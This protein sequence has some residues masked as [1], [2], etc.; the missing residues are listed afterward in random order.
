MSLINQVFGIKTKQP[1][2]ATIQ[3]IF[4]DYTT[5]KKTEAGI[6]VGVNEVV[7]YAPVSQALQMISGDIAK[8][9]LNVYIRQPSL[10][11]NA[12]DVDKKHQAY[13]IVKRRANEQQSA[14]RFWSSFVYQQLLWNNAYAWIKRNPTNGR[15]V[16]LYLLRPDRTQFSIKDGLYYSEIGSGV[17]AEVIALKP[18]DVLHYQGNQV[19][20]VVEPSL[21]KNARTSISVGLAAVNHAA[22]FFGGDCN[23]GGILE[24]PASFEKRAKDNLEQGFQKK[25]AGQA[26]QTVILRDG[27]RFHSIQI[28]AEKSQM[29]ETRTH[30]AR[31]MANW[32]NLPPSKLGIPDAGGYGSRTED[33]R[34]YYDQTLSSRL[35]DISS[36]CDLKLLTRAQQNNDSHYFEHDAT[37]LL[38]M[39][40]KTLAEIYA[41]ESANGATSPDEYRAATN[42]NPRPDGEGGRFYQP[43]ANYV[44]V[45]ESSDNSEQQT[46]TDNQTMAILNAVLS[47]QV[48][49]WEAGSIAVIKKECRR[50]AIGKFSNWLNNFDGLKV[51]EKLEERTKKAGVDFNPSN[52]IENVKREIAN[53]VSDVM[54]DDWQN[55]II[56]ICEG[57]ENV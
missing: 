55:E 34:N 13:S 27:A 48:L 35:C 20:G 3:E 16:G 1:Q 10:G 30:Q 32:F 11:P 40:R 39:D 17:D 42:R 21:L 44:P 49:S 4:Q 6:S 5:S 18:N 26:F 19:P 33:N 22:K 2:A 52:W 53:N 43:N 8:M 9:K 37:A 15:T 14:F 38:A 46:E 25:Y 50:K 45:E 54:S 41:I 12:R 57:F 7:S 51:P 23:A 31:E 24:I 29:N 56:T 47:E 36:E 28:D